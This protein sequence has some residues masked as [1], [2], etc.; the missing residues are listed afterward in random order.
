MTTVAVIGASRGIGHELA[1]QY[2]AD[3]CRVHATTRTPDRPSALGDV[4]GDVHMHQLDVVEDDQIAALAGAL[5]RVD[6][7]MG[8]RGALAAVGRE[9][10]DREFTED[11]VVAAYLAFFDEVVG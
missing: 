2:A 11:A 3:G 10:F 9:A 8:L 7:D 4:D 1:R 6:G 5:A